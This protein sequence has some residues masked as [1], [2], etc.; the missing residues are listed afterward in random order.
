MKIRVNKKNLKEDINDMVF[1]YDKE[2]KRHW[3]S[4]KPYDS[5]IDYVSPVVV[6]GYTGKGWYDVEPFSDK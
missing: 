4:A 3:S 6:T 5:G 1:N 2:Y